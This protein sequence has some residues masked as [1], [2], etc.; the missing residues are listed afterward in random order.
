MA[1]QRSSTSQRRGLCKFFLQN[2]GCKNGDKCVFSHSRIDV[3]SAPSCP[4]DTRQICQ[5][6]ASGACTFG[7]TCRFQHSTEPRTPPNLDATRRCIFHIQGKCAKGVSCAF[8]HTETPAGKVVPKCKYF[9]QGACMFGSNCRFEHEKSPDCE[10]QAPDV[11]QKVFETVKFHDNM[12]ALENHNEKVQWPVL[13]DGSSQQESTAGSKDSD[14]S[15]PLTASHVIGFSEVLFGPGA[16]VDQVITPFESNKVV[17]TGLPG[18]VIQSELMGLLEEYGHLRNVLIHADTSKTVSPKADAEFAS[19][20]EARAAVDSLNGRE[21]RSHVLHVAFQLHAGDNG[22]ATLRSCKVKLSWY[23]PSRIAWAHYKTISTAKASA[24]RLKDQVIDGRKIQANFQSPSRRQRD[25]FTVS[26]V[27]LSPT[28]DYARLR[29]EFQTNDVAFGVPTYEQP[30]AVKTLRRTLESYGSVE[31]L[32]IL[33]NERNLKV[34]AFAQFSISDAADAA[35]KGIHNIPQTWLGNGR[36]FLELIHSV[37]YNVP[38]RQ[39]FILKQAIEKISSSSEKCSI[40][41]YD[42][43]NNGIPLDPVCIRLYSSDAK[44]LGRS[45]ASLEQLLEGNIVS[46][47]GEALWD[48]YFQTADGSSFLEHVCST[49][50][51]YVRC[52]SRTRRLHLVGKSEDILRADEEIKRKCAKLSSERHIL[53]LEKTDLRR[54]MLN[55]DRL[56]DLAGQNKL[57]LD[58]VSRTLTI[59]GS[60][61]AVGVIRSFIKD[62]L[63][64]AAVSNAAA[65]DGQEVDCPVCFCE[66][67][68]PLKLHC[69]HSYCSEC[70][71]HLLHAASD[72]N[73]F[74]VTCVALEGKCGQALPLQIFRDF[75]SPDAERHLYKSA[76]NSYIHQRPQEYRYCPTPD[77]QT[78]YR[79]GREG[80]ALRCPGCL[81]RIC[82]ACNVEFHDGLTCH[83]Q[84]YESSAEKEEFLQWK[85]ANGV[86]PCPKCGADLEKNGGCNH[87]KCANCRTHMCWVCME[88]FSEGG[89]VYTHMNKMHGGI[90]IDIEGIF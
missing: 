41:C 16:S 51:I 24:A 13:T 79:P 54:I 6:F 59:S 88:T 17:I 78:I 11:P 39:Y 37:R 83:D 62:V 57:T 27:G 19:P 34:K 48:E 50:T 85:A 7:S 69:G 80:T 60:D 67:D 44:A 74:P 73:N 23:A 70:L 55:F 75:L 5:F 66:P 14:A 28:T 8:S 72:T 15:D 40:R 43:D 20:A 56:Q 45:K 58:V 42:C 1:F 71:K 52:D 21:F 36:L 29:R 68:A 4:K 46:I 30:D 87:I 3:Q 64:G 26:I 2:G 22:L 82:P 89:G 32:E 86:R 12:S 53:I 25:S 90:G 38:H 63:D 49:Y 76:F 9:S 77:C 31:N 33:A 18:G 84:K 65:T 10:I 47:G 81:N 61:D 35:V